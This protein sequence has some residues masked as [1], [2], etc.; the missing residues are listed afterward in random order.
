[1]DEELV[2][3]PDTLNKVYA[4]LTE[5]GLTTGQAV[6]AVCQLQNRGILFR[7]RKK[8]DVAEVS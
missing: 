7:E 5:A 2:H 4:A 3:T 8:V 1:M 6:N